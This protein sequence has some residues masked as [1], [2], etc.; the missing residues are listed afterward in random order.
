MI[1]YIKNYIN[2]IK[3]INYNF[4]KKNLDIK[5]KYIVDLEII[6][7]KKDIEEI[8]INIK[9]EDILINNSNDRQLQINILILIKIY[10]NTYY[11][12][13]NNEKFNNK[14]YNIFINNKFI[15]SNLTEYNNDKINI[16]NKYIIEYIKKRNNVIKYL[17]SKNKIINL[18]NNIELLNNINTS[19]NYI[20]IL[21]I[22]DMS[23]KDIFL[24]CYFL[25]NKNKDIMNIKNILL[26]I[27]IKYNNQEIRLKVDSFIE[28]TKF[29]NF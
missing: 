9:E 2:N 13:T 26:S 28:K 21:F 11:K 24:Y 3:L 22:L 10:T 8:L 6:E 15:I 27:V 23:I 29:I 5:E 1:N 25:L 12:Y 18:K 14:L 17:Q 19:N 4:F 20:D 7:E 16:F